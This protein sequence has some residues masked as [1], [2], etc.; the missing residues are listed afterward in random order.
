MEHISNFWLNPYILVGLAVVFLLSISILLLRYSL[1]RKLCGP[2]YEC[3]DYFVR[4]CHNIA[5]YSENQNYISKY[6]PIFEKCKKN[7]SAWYLG[8]FGKT[9]I[10]KFLAWY[11]ETMSFITRMNSFLDSN[12][13]FAHSELLSC[14]EGMEIEQK[15]S[16]FFTRSF[17]RYVSKHI[18]ESFL[19]L[20]MY[21]HEINR[22]FSVI[23]QKHN[24]TF[25]KEEL[26]RNKEYFDTVLKY[27]LDVQ[28]RDSIVKLEDNCLVISS[29]G[30]GKTSTSVAKIKYLIER[31]HIAP[32]NIL[33]LTYTTKAA[34]E[35]TDRLG[36]E[37]KGLN[38]YTFHSLAFHILAQTTHEKPDICDSNTMLKCFYHLSDTNPNFK[39]AINEFLTEE[40]SLTKDA[41]DYLTAEAYYRDRA[42][43]GIQAPYLDM[44]GRIIFTR[45]EEEKKIC[46]FLSE[47]GVPFRYEQPYFKDTATTDNRQYRPDF[48]IYFNC[49]GKQYFIIY[50]HFGIDAK[51]NV[52]QW[53]GE[54]KKGGF[55]KANKDYNDGIVW[56]REVNKKY[57]TALIETTS[58]MFQDGTL[59]DKLTLQLLQYGITLHPLSE[60]EKFDKLVKRN[61][62]MEDSIL[63]LISTFIT[64]MKSNRKTTD[65]IL[66][67]IKEEKQMYPEFIKRSEFM[68]KN[69]FEPFY[70]EY[71]DYL[72]QRHQIDYTDLILKATDICESGMYKKEYDMILVDEFQDI[73]IDRYKM[74][75]SLRRKKNLTKLYCVGDDWQSIF[76]F[77][78]SDLSLFNRFEE[79]FGFTEKCAIETTYRFGNPAIETSSKFI[80]ANPAQVVKNIKPVNESVKTEV[81]TE[82]YDVD[83]KHESHIKKL[84]SIILGIPKEESIMI[85]GRYHYDAEIFG[86]NIVERNQKR[87]IVNVNLCSRKIPYNTIHSAKGLE[88][89]HVIILNCSQDGSGFPSRV[90]DDPI[91]GY[92]LSKPEA[93]SYAEERRLF[94]VAITRAKKHTYVMYNRSCPSLFVAEL[95]M[96]T[97]SMICPQC[98]CGT[99]KLLKDG[100]NS[101]QKWR[102]YGCTNYTAHCSYTYFVNFKQEDEILSDFERTCNSY[103][104]R[105]REDQ[106]EKLK[107]EKP[108]AKYVIVPSMP[109]PPQPFFQRAA[110][111]L[112]SGFPY[113]MPPTTSNMDRNDENDVNELPF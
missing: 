49:N 39:Q 82:A 7:K 104:L 67:A 89:D 2:I 24:R 80:L 3:V 109:P 17:H 103:I 33:P 73:S 75:Q 105:I 6:Q 65:S 28:Q 110:M 79:Y 26:E 69:I 86:N 87:D 22:D 38:C 88:A 78:G 35:L 43:Y 70:K 91:L 66:D 44:D 5:F 77:S 76:R 72:N 94:Y 37:D 1:N 45:S 64:L 96:Q 63:Q 53:F 85:I 51:G 107:K 10:D 55:A 98:K 41:H 46:T 23:P 111:P 93:F 56:K 4:N 18:T 106:V 42:L 32:S 101:F 68:L 31:R 60:E 19:D 50:E 29:A 47:N 8:I 61:K 113:P 100:G 83:E 12:H 21:E 71:Q 57:N 27:P 14:F 40:K 102:L 15:T 13:Y 84:E 62:K 74:L 112:P 52:P 16:R 59:Y 48:T 30:S 36:L 97:G 90:S 99:L 34:K 92:V 54:G 95:Q 81:T 108:H 58:A 25:V 9:L 11:D 20:D